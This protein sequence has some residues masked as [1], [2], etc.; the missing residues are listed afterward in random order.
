MKRFFFHFQSKDDS[1][2]DVKGCEFSDL[3]SA[4]R[5]AMLLIQKIVLFD[6]IDWRGWSIKVTDENN[7]SLLSVLFPQ[8]SYLQFGNI[9]KHLICD[10]IG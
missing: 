10:T 2:C 6:D 8:M 1:I 9:A 3:Y 5:H 7:R 4:H